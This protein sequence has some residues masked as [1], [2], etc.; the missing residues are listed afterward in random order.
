MICVEC[1]K[2]GKTYNGLCIDCYL[3]KKKLFVIP[4]EIEVT[5]C[6]NCSAYKINKKKKWKKGD[7][8]KDLQDYLREKIKAEIDFK[9]SF[10]GK[11]AI[12]TGDFEGK[13]VVEKKEI[14]INKEYRLC[15]K[16][17]LKKG[18]Y[19]EAIIQIRNARNYMEIEKLIKKRIK[20]KDAFISKKE[21]VKGG[22]DYYVG[23]KKVAF[24]IAKEIKE[25]FKGEINISS[26]LV[27]LKNGRKI[28][29]DTYRIKF[30]EYS[31]GDFVKIN[32]SLYRIVS[33]GKKIELEDL[34]GRKKYI[35]KNE[36][37]RIAKIKMEE[38]DAIV[39]YEDEKGLYVMDAKNYKTFFI[40]K[41]KKWKKGKKIKIIEYED[42][43]YG[44]VK[45]D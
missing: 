38:K 40:N 23:N 35:Y 18:G 21:E 8:I 7:L 32:E 26:S 11:I 12:C 14:T 29:R 37:E 43:I 10:D 28:Y 16:C 17:S 44:V 31:V 15:N 30:P 45:D 22:I 4:D 33:I 25:K 42:R 27:G 39:L 20:E 24:T 9:L 1:G 13:E 3:K 19:Y 41:P 2:K 5:F 34:E 6:K 36:I